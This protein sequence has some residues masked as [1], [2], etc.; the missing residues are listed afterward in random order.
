MTFV[1]GLICGFVGTF[2][3]GAIVLLFLMLG[4]LN[5]TSDSAKDYE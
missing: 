2:I 5:E 3:V 1:F 4:F